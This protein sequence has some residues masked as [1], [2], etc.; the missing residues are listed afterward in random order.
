MDVQARSNILKSKGA[1][2]AGIKIIA[3]T[4]KAGARAHKMA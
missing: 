4:M 1:N 3:V 2:S